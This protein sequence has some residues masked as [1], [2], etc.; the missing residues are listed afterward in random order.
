M[1][2]NSYLARKSV[3]LGKGISSLLLALEHSFDHT[4]MVGSEVDEACLHARLE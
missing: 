1:Q 2:G 4:G 3:N